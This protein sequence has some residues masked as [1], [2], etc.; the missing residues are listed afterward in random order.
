[1]MHAR[2]TVSINGFNGIHGWDYPRRVPD[3]LFSL[4]CAS[5][6]NWS[7]PDFADFFIGIGPRNRCTGGKQP[8]SATDGLV[9]ELKDIRSMLVS[10]GDD[11]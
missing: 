3:V 4:V 1:M 2:L 6:R 7:H 10:S 9:S 5:G 8:R 11:C